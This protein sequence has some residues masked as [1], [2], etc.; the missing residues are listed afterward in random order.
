MA[1]GYT[2]FMGLITITTGVNDKIGW[3]EQSA[4]GGPYGL[5]ETIPAGD[6][7]PDDD[8]GSDLLATMKA[9]MEA[10]SDSAGAGQ[11]YA[12]DGFNYTFSIDDDTG[13]VTVSAN[14][15]SWGVGFQWY[16]TYQTNTADRIWSGGSQTAG[17]HGYQG[18]GWNVISPSSPWGQSFT[19]D[20]SH[21]NSWYPNQPIQQG[22][23]PKNR[24]IV[25]EA[26]SGGGDVR[27]YDFTGNPEDVADSSGVSYLDR[28]TI[29]YTRISETNR[30]WWF[31]EFW[32]PYAKQ[33]LPDGRFRFYEDRS[34]A[35][36][37]TCG[38]TGEI[39]RESNFDRT[40]TG[41]P[42]WT[43]SFDV[44]RYKP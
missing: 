21:S 11:D 17:R 12:G 5:T 36:Y 41:Y 13:L 23:R 2:K 20:V 24:S 35:A 10:K 34:A 33:G 32:R 16:P 4:L 38:L 22:T 42:L 3:V 37:H 25:V 26:E 1:F 28:W 15:T 9:L 44:K 6:Y 8:G 39:L 31:K 43:I 27:T 29:R 30:L 14:H 40:I 7:W 18:L 19:S